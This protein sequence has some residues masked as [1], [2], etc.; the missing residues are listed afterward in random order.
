MSLR[1]TKKYS[2]FYELNSQLAGEFM[3][4]VRIIN[5]TEQVRWWKGD[6]R[7]ETRE[8]LLFDF[9]KLLSSLTI[10]FRS[11]NKPARGSL[12]FLSWLF[13]YKELYKRT[14]TKRPE[15]E[16]EPHRENQEKFSPKTRSRIRVRNEVML[17]TFGKVGSN[18][19][20]T[21]DTVAGLRIARAAREHRMRNSQCSARTVPN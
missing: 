15:R 21:I 10:L 1:T 17:G 14:S 7:A 5:S 11:S 3:K 2:L 4:I 16:E 12:L 6:E 20:R 9:T 13:S 8:R 18:A 19:R